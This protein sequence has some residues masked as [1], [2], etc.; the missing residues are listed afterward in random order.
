MKTINYT[1]SGNQNSQ[2]CLVFIH[3]FAGDKND[4]KYQ[5]TY[6]AREY[7]TLAL[8]LPGHGDSLKLDKSQQFDMISLANDINYLITELNIQQKLII[9]GHS[10]ASRL[11]LEVH[12]LINAAGAVLID[13]SYQ[14]IPNPDFNQ[15][16]REVTVPGYKT[17]IN[18]LFRSKF[19]DYTP[20]ELGK[21]I[22]NKALKLEESIAALLYPNIRI[23]DYYSIPKALRL[24]KNPLLII[25][26]SFYADGQR[27]PH[28][29]SEW[30]NLVKT[31][32]PHAQIKLIPDCGHWVMLEQSELCNQYIDEFLYAHL[33]IVNN[34]PNIL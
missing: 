12:L 33:M 25:Q 6:F 21:D 31:N 8:D 15:I 16:Q 2:L 26:A 27:V 4:W 29:D 5:I 28:T 22:I 13:C 3:G 1:L 32:T 14:K 7:L 11:A 34:L 10:M 17:W 24:V 23:Y 30:L 9:V 19:G 18:Q 20:A